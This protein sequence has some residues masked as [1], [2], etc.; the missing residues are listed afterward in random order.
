MLKSLK[1]LFNFPIVRWTD[2]T[3][4]EF[5]HLEADEFFHV[6]TGAEG[7]MFFTKNQV[8]QAKA[9]AAKNLEDQ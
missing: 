5:A 9:R 2:N 3:Q 4:K 1:R 8:K 7:V 6:E